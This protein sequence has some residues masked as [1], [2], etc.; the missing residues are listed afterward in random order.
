LLETFSQGIQ[1]PVCRLP[2]APAADPQLVL[3]LI[4]TQWV[5]DPGQRAAN[6]WIIGISGTKIESRVAGSDALWIYPGA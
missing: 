1:L 4:E 6:G 3:S 2:L 5:A